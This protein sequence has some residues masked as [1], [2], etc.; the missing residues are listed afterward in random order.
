[1]L[2]RRSTA[3]QRREGARERET[4]SQHH[5]AHTTGAVQWSTHINTPPFSSPLLTHTRLVIQTEARRGAEAVQCAAALSG[6]PC[7]E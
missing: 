1:M 5:L 2:G 3:R 4:A 6:I 7:S